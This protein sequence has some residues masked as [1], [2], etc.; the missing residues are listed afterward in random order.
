MATAGT[1]GLNP[2]PLP[3]HLQP[4]LV[5]HPC[6]PPGGWQGH[7]IFP[8]FVVPGTGPNEQTPAHASPPRSV[9]KPATA[10]TKERV[11]ITYSDDNRDHMKEV[12]KMAYLLSGQGYVVDV[13]KFQRHFAAMDKIG[14]LEDKVENVSEI[15]S[16][17]FFYHGHFGDIYY[18]HEKWRYSFGC[19]CL[20]AFVPGFL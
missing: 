9:Q 16:C 18:L 14:W 7:Y 19:V 13:D 15:Q 6:A 4:G 2:W 3:H 12:L 1:T 17:H 20:C 5:Y 10:P 8:D 11:F